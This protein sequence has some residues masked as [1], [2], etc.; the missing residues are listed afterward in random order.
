MASDGSVIWNI[1]PFGLTGAAATIQFR[2]RS[3]REPIPMLKIAQALVLVLWIPAAL[4]QPGGKNEA[5]FRYRGADRDARL[6]ERAKQ[7]GVVAFYT[8]LAPTE[9]MP[10][11]EAFEKKH[12]IKV[13]LWRALSD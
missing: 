7:E 5:I 11:A 13:E 3:I 8:S 12:G 4:A 9:S 6:V 2:G 10:L 1:V